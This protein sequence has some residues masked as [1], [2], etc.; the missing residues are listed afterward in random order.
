MAS[1]FGAFFALSVLRLSVLALALLGL[2][3]VFLARLLPLARRSLLAFSLFA[4]SLLAGPLITLP[5]IRLLAMLQDAL[6]RLTIVGAV[7][8]DGVFG[9]CF[10]LLTTGLHLTVAT[11]PLLPRA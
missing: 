9:R 4:L 11:A 1:G 7:G 8:G 2:S 6:H 10:A 3:A 5:R